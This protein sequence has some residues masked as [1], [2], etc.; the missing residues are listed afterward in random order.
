MDIKKG[1][2]NNFISILQRLLHKK[3]HA[4]DISPVVVNHLAAA[5]LTKQY[6]KFCSCCPACKNN[7]LTKINVKYIFFFSLQNNTRMRI[8]C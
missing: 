5:G 4:N 1:E 6:F 3:L 2:T 7:F 8:I